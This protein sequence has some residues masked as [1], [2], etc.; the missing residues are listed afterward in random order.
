MLAKDPKDRPTAVECL[1]SRF[2]LENNML[3]YEDIT[4]PIE[5]FLPKY[6]N[7]NNIRKIQPVSL[8][9]TCKS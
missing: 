2:F 3:L 1:E 6:Q 4:V 5:G 8:T 9:G 7:L